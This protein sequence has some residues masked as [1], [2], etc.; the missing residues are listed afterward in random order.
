MLCYLSN[1]NRCLQRR[2]EGRN[3]N[4]S[5]RFLLP[6]YTC[7]IC[8]LFSRSCSLE[9]YREKSGHSESVS[10]WPYPY[11]KPGVLSAMRPLNSGLAG[12]LRSSLHENYS[13]EE[14]KEYGF[15]SVEQLVVSNSL[16]NHIKDARSTRELEGQ[17][18]LASLSVNNLST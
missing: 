15:H 18:R 4:R 8:H 1:V 14:L 11:V 6:K 17:Q 13:V 16:G 3:S 9:E 7:N 12:C 5:S 2:V 10:H